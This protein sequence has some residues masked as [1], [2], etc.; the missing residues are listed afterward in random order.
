LR[1]HPIAKAGLLLVLF[2]AVGLAVRYLAQP[3]GS[4]ASRLAL[5]LPALSAH[6]GALLIVIA[7]FLF[8]ARAPIRVPGYHRA[9]VIVACVV[10]AVLMIAGQA[11]LTVAAITGAPLTPTVFRTFRGIHV[12][13]S[14]EFLEPLKANALLVSAGLVFFAGVLIWM[15]RLVVGGGSGLA[16][17]V[18]G[19]S[20]TGVRL[21]ADAT[22]GRD[23]RS[24]GARA[25]QASV[26]GV[27]LLFLP[28]IVPW[29]GPPAPIEVAFATEYLGLD[30]TRLRGSEQDAIRDLRDLVGLPPHTRWIGDEYPLVYERIDPPSAVTP[31]ER[32]DIIV[33]MVES[34]RAEALGFVTGAHD[35][36]SPNLDA[37]ALRGVAFPTFTSNGFPSA[38]SVLS[39]HCSA[40]P[41]RRKEIITDFAD[42]QFDCLPPRLRDFGYDTIYIGADP[43]FD[44]Q[45][46]WLGQWYATVVDL[47]AHGIE[48]TD[49]NIVARAI[50]E[51]QRHDAAPSPSP[52]FEFVSTYSM[53]YPFRIPDDAHE[54]PVADTAHL[55]ERYRQ[56]L[57]YTDREIGGL[58]SFLE[59]RARRDRTVTIVVG[60]HG[61]YTDL[62]RTSG[63]PE[64]DNVWTAA[65]VAGSRERVG[66]PRRIVGAASHVD[67]LPTVLALAGDTRPSAALGRDLF[68]PPRVAKPS[69]LAV[70]PGGLRFDRDGYAV[71]VDAR[72]P[73]AATT[74]V[75][76]PELMPPLPSSS[77]ADVTA[78]RLTNWITAWSYLIE[79]DR[80]WNPSLADP[81]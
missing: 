73:N 76:F 48:A 2:R 24:A 37:L 61:F 16:Y 68:G 14:N 67:M 52:L 57:R 78:E 4:I 34:L 6:V 18:S 69:A 59:T 46:R 72:T 35:S 75:A 3:P 55:S 5:F 43:H 62:R 64:N 23:Y 58:V 28:S 56:V 41:H 9:V 25:F 13:T 12:V 7:A 19:F 27:V 63:V 70:R 71:V 21:K 1:A 30:R 66:D 51:I 15:A 42:R 26:L 60:D 74:R 39:F 44:N 50:D 45:D 20:R 11:D 80:V 38:P 54:T 33:V 31:A 10:F 81:R 65:I 29:P 47:V 8:L 32:P 77:V 17:V 53:H 36:V 49:R 79:K 40:W 22:Y